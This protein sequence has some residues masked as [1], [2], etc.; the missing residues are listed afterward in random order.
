MGGTHSLTPPT[1][2]NQT[3]MSL[4]YY[5]SSDKSE[6]VKEPITCPTCGTTCEWQSATQMRYKPIYKPV[7]SLQS[8]V[9]AKDARIELLEGLLREARDT[10]PDRFPAMKQRITTALSGTQT[11]KL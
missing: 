10:F 9:A 2:T 4:Q 8:E 5:T 11:E 7:S 3:F 6:P 1:N